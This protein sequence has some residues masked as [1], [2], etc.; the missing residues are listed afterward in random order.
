MFINYEYKK[1]KLHNFDDTKKV[2]ALLFPLVS[3]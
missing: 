3:L 1:T 2:Y